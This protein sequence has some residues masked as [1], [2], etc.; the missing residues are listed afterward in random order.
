MIR[1]ADLPEIQ[2]ALRRKMRDEGLSYRSVYKRASRFGPISYE[3]VCRL[4]SGE[5]RYP[6]LTTVLYVLHALDFEMYVCDV[7]EAIR[8][9]LRMCA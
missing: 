3:T 5:T 6:R 8:E 9:E 7:A 1:I 4:L 2:K